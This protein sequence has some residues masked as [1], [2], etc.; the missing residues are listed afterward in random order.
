MRFLI[1]ENMALSCAAV[2][3]EMGYDASHVSEIGLTATKDADITLFARENQY[4][5]VTFDLDF[6]RIVALSSRTFPSIITFRT[7]EVNT[8][9]FAALMRENLQHLEEALLSGAL[10]TIDL[11]GVRI[12]RLPVI[13]K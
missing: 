11:N 5:I 2:L 9:I 12:Q 8:T 10:V 6:S 7:G 1:D 3:I 13:P 4:I